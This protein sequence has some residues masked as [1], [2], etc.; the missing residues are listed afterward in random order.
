MLKILSHINILGSN[1]YTKIITRKELSND[2]KLK[3]G[4]GGFK[5]LQECW[6][7]GYIRMGRLCGFVLTK[8]GF[9]KYIELNDL[10]E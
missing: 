7:L 4:K 1:P 2:I 6:K 10:K 9:D 3:Y 8:K 5:I